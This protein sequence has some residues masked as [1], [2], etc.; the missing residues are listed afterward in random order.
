MAIEKPIFF[1][2]MPRSDTTILFEAFAA[3]EDLGWLSNYSYRFPT[4]PHITLIHRFFRGAQGRKNQRRKLAIH[5]RL[6]PE[7]QEVY[8]IWERLLGRKFLVTFLTNCWPSDEEID[9][10]RQFMASVLRA[11]G[12]RRFCAKFT[13]P[14][15]IRFLSKIFPDAYFVDVI[16]DPR[17]VVSSLLAVTFWK[18]DGLEKPYWDGALGEKEISIWRKTGNSPVV[19]AALQW[20]SVYEATMEEIRDVTNTYFRVKYEEFMDAPLESISQIGSFC[21]LGSCEK[22][23]RYIRQQQYENM[24]FKFRKDLSSDDIKIVEEIAEKYMRELGYLK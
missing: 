23:E 7:P 6:L 16:R 18:K 11:E 5:E 9:K 15:R 13:G 17:A 21:G 3:H 12:K 22:L 20:C 10:C 8:N 19:L 1:I 24:N 4:I 14:P 2:G